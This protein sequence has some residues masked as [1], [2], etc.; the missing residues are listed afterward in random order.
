MLTQE[1]LSSTLLN[2]DGRGY[3]AYLEIKGRYQFA[4][5]ALIVDRVQGDPFAS[6]SQLRIR[7]PHATARFPTSLYR[8]RSREVA[9]RDYLARQFR[10]RALQKSDRRGTGKSGLI[11]IAPVGQ[12]I[13]A[14]TAVLIDDQGIEVRFVAGLP[15]RGR[16]I[17][18]RQ[19]AEMLCADLPD[20]VRETLKYDALKGSEIKQHVEIAEDADWLRQQLPERG[21]VAFIPNGAV[22]PRRSGADDR[23]LQEQAVPF[24]SPASLQVEFSCPNRGPVAGMGI[25]AG[26]TLI[27]GGGYHGKS[28]VLRSLEVGVYNHV[29][30]DGRE[31]VVTNPAAVKIRA[32]DGRSIAGVNI[33]PFINHLPQGRST[34]CFSTTNASG[35]TSQA[36]NIMEALEAGVQVL[37][38]DEDTSATNFTIRDRRMQEL[39]GKEK[40]PITPFIDKVRQLYEEYGVS[41]ILVMGGSGDYFD[42]ADTAIA[43]DNFQPLEVTEKAKQIARQ[44]LSDRL[45]EGGQQFG[46]ITPRIPLPDSIDPSRGRR[47]VKVKVR[48]VD[49]VAFGTEEID[50]AAVEQLVEVGQ[51]R[52]IAAAIVTAKERYLDG[53]T[54]LPAI[55]EQTMAEI[56]ERG[57]DAIAEPDRGDLAQ[58]RRF[59]L[60]AVL[61]R[62]RS[63]QVQLATVE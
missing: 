29:P 59:E 9:L 41:S 2:L 28:T 31:L 24:Q 32:E 15:A 36:A 27:V 26:I 51:L 25:P 39:I 10:Q 13:L 55:L 62:L 42:V 38:V 11:G 50:L 7:V 30:G 56:A 63:L 22:L 1:I 61:N 48:D 5:F 6:P 4:D 14:R 45:P 47:A 34:V 52:A 3:K 57:L 19:A 43:M 49:E 12:E 37:L 54:A 8:S 23:P 17:L 21:L 40:E 18:G 53:K 46:T 44:Y 20:L 33:S 16:R 60:A 58:F 35:S